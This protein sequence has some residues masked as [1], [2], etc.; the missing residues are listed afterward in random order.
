VP[1]RVSLAVLHRFQILVYLKK[2]NL[3]RLDLFKTEF[4]LLHNGDIR[5]YWEDLIKFDLILTH[6]GH[7]RGIDTGKGTIDCM[8]SMV[9][10]TAY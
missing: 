5:T 4:N 9:I 2:K 10:W 8:G 3:Y 7:E 6:E 1:G